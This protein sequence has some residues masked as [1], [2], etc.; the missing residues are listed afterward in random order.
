MRVVVHG[1]STALLAMRSG[2]LKADGSQ[3]M[4][5]SWIVLETANE[6]AV[7]RGSSES[8]QQCVCSDAR[9]WCC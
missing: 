8:R 3:L 1:C 6:W 9:V 2:G 7:G 5:H 4:D